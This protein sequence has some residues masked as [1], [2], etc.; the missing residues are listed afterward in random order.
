MNLFGLILSA[1]FLPVDYLDKSILHVVIN[2]HFAK[3][4][5]QKVPDQTALILEAV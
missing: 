1:E 5:K 4:S 2:K 3:E